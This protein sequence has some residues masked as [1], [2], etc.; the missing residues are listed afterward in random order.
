MTV[1]AIP[2]IEPL[3]HVA[4]LIPRGTQLAK[5][6]IGVEILVVNIGA[7]TT[8]MGTRSGRRR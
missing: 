4:N 8:L 5:R 7:I 1:S 2:S 3:L 6:F